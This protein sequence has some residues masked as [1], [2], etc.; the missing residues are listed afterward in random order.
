MTAQEIFDKVLQHLRNQKC[1]AAHQNACRYRT[2]N[3]NKCAVGCLLPENT[4]TSAF[5][6]VT[7]DSLG[8]AFHAPLE[9]KQAALAAALTAAG[10]DKTHQRLLGD[11]QYAHDDALPFDPGEPL[12]KWE[13]AMQQIAKHHGL[14]YSPA[15]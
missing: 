3:G 15:N 2:P 10:I 6:G 8:M 9:S 14:T 5:E 12:E 4:A 13:N 7:V 1:K 11:L